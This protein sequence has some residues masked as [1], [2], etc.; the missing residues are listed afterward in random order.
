M[1][2]KSFVLDETFSFLGQP[3]FQ[4]TNSSVGLSVF[5]S[6]VC[7]RMSPSGEALCLVRTILWPL[8]NLL[9]STLSKK[10]VE[11]CLLKAHQINKQRIQPKAYHC[12]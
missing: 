3:D 1:I 5:F 4:Q 12:Q 9:L 7:V 10:D 6:S 11:I 2:R 8:A